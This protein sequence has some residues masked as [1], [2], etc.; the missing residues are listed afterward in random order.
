MWELLDKVADIGALA[1]KTLLFYVMLCNYYP[2]IAALITV[3]FVL[4]FASVILRHAQQVWGTATEWTKEGARG[5]LLLSGIASVMTATTGVYLIRHQTKIA[6]LIDFVT[7]DYPVRKAPV[8]GYSAYPIVVVGENATFHWHVNEAPQLERALVDKGAILAFHVRYSRSGNFEK[9]NPIGPL[10]APTAVLHS[11]AV[12]PGGNIKV[13]G[14]DE[15]TEINTWKTLPLFPISDIIN[16]DIYYQVQ[17]LQI[18]RDSLDSTE[19]TIARAEQGGYYMEGPL[20]AAATPIGAWSNVLHVERY[21]SALAK[22]KARR[23]ISVATQF[24]GEDATYLRFYR[25]AGD[26]GTTRFVGLEQTISERILHHL[27]VKLKEPSLQISWHPVDDFGQ[28]FLE[29]SRDGVDLLMSGITMSANREEKYGLRFSKPYLQS[30]FS[31]AYLGQELSE[32]D[33]TKQ[34]REQTITA[35]RGTTSYEI[36]QRINPN[37]L[38]AMVDIESALIDIRDGKVRF[39]IVDSILGRSFR[40]DKTRYPGIQVADLTTA[41]LRVL[42]GSQSPGGDD[43]I[44]TGQKYAIA[45]KFDRSLELLHEINQALAEMPSNAEEAAR[46]DYIKTLAA[47]T[48]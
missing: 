5:K 42:F 8:G 31:V 32:A 10:P 3:P 40:S 25:N 29:P 35:S 45:V 17:A 13:A 24:P 1:K 16:G 7:F 43:Y 6:P 15:C 44:T 34:L 27:R 38:Q 47:T 41:D 39:M 37:N 28:I 46:T 14:I 11:E 48:D 19:K 9:C 22:I 23:Y 4:I 20:T 21:S 36:G 26:F 2:I 30:D 12:P 18:P 33:L